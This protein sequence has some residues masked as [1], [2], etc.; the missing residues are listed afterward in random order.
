MLVF[1]PIITAGIL[2]IGFK[3]RMAWWEFLIPFGASL[4]TRLPASTSTTTNTAYTSGG[5]VTSQ[6]LNPQGR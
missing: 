3:R 1:V 5:H 2:L 4:V 6:Y